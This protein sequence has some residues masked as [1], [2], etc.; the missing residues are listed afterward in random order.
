[1]NIIVT[2]ASQG[3]GF[4]TAKHLAAQGHT[5]VAV[6][7]NAEKLKRLARECY[8]ADP[9]AK[10]FLISFDLSK[11]GERTAL[12]PEIVKRFSSVD[13]V[14]H[15]AGAFVRKPLQSI[16]EEEIQHVYNTNVFSVIRLTQALIPYLSKPSHVLSISSM[17]G[18]QGSQKFPGM[19]IYSSSKAAL[20]NL[21]ECFAEEFK[22]S[23]IAFNCLALG[24][25]DTA[26]LHRAFPGYKAEVSPKEMGEYIADFAL[27]GH[28]FFNGKVIPVSLS[29]P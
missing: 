14:I 10:L 1:M 17:G 12:V 27:T 11:S 21:T 29:T 25:V 13:V 5:V 20:I 19:S 4:E 15:N 3:I 23:G 22:G 16:S 28:R 26:M 8:A 18:I 9:S 6:A 24:A 2:G 7:R